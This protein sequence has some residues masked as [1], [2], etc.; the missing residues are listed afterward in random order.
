MKSSPESSD[1]SR[2]SLAS[3]RADFRELRTNSGA[4]VQ[5][6]RDFLK[7]LKGRSPQEMLGVVSSSQLFRATLLS[8][9]LVALTILALTA[10]PY[11]L[12]DEKANGK[13]AA[14]AP[15]P[16]T[17]P[18]EPTPAPAPEPQTQPADKA[19]GTLGI[20]EQ[21]TAP[22]NSNPLEEEKDDFL[23]DLE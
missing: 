11:F 5:E 14:A 6:L 23:K 7:E 20:N 2:T 19:P 4:T 21:L 1:P 9:L 22:P 3:T 16:V 12:G 15:A 18:A 17:T 13:T 8:C 10:G